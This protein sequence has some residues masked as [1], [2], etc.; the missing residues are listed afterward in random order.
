MNSTME[1]PPT[2]FTA[3]SEADRQRFLQEG[4]NASPQHDVLL[5][6]RN[7][8][9]G[10]S[11]AYDPISTPPNL[12]PG[13]RA[14]A[15][16]AAEL[17]FAQ[18]YLGGDVDMSMI[19]VKK[20]KDIFLNGIKDMPD[21]IIQ[22]AVLA[23][24]ADREHAH[25]LAITSAWGLEKIE[26]CVRLQTK[27]MKHNAKMYADKLA[28]ASFFEALLVKRTR[29][30][31]EDDA[32]FTI[33]AYVEDFMV[34]TVADMKLDQLEDV[35]DACKLDLP[36]DDATPESYVNSHLDSIIAGADNIYPWPS[37]F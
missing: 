12:P 23:A 16:S 31:L 11:T 22:D 25:L 30:Q 35:A 36:M 10:E 6:A 5:E 18:K 2:G 9:S 28:E 24:Q 26:W 19:D 8:N 7:S 13:K 37:R 21:E 1:P 33:A 27:I 29:P 3:H 4:S 14:D 17:R 34:F 20:G 15:P 32:D